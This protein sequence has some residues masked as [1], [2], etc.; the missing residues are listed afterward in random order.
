MLCSNKLLVVGG[1]SA[2]GEDA[3][4]FFQASGVFCDTRPLRV[5]SSI[6]GGFFSKKHMF[7][8]SCQLKENLMSYGVFRGAW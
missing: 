1:S 4:A 5:L 7:H 6:V 2:L 3:L 8:L